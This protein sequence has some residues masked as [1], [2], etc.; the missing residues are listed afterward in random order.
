M[1]NAA[2]RDA[3]PG[4]YVVNDAAGTLEVDRVDSHGAN[5]SEREEDQELPHRGG[6]RTLA[7]DASRPRDRG[8]AADLQEGNRHK[9]RNARAGARRGALLGVDR[10]RSQELR[11][12]FVSPAVH[13]A[14]AQEPL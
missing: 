1:S 10:R 14:W 11:R 8:M 7:R 13:P 4:S 9:D 3:P 6:V 5:R 12:A 2:S